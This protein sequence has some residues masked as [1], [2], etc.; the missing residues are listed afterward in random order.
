MSGHNDQRAGG[1][2]SNIPASGKER[3][4]DWLAKQRMEWVQSFVNPRDVVLEYG[5]RITSILANLRAAKKLCV[6]LESGEFEPNP[7]R[8]EF[9]AS[10]N[11]M[12]AETADLIFCDHVLEYLPDPLSVITDLKRILKPSGKLLVLALYDDGYRSLNAVLPADHFFSWNVQS[13]GNLLTDCGFTVI[14]G[15]VHRSAYERVAKEWALKLGGGKV[16]WRLAAHVSRLFA[17]QFTVCVAGRK[18]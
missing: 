6:P 3:I 14:H 15:A 5:S 18:S 2:G 11:G 12:E 10:L 4:P 16:S 7:E 13:L 17:P 8:N 9:R 1:A